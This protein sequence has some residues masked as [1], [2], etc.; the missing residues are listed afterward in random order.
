MRV[1]FTSVIA[2]AAGKLGGNSFSTKHGRVGVANLAKLQRPPSSRQ[3]KNRRIMAEASRLWRTITPAERQKWNVLVK[4]RT[5]FA[6]GSGFKVET[7]FA[8][9]KRKIYAQLITFGSVL[10]TSADP[11]PP[12]TY[13]TDCIAIYTRANDRLVLSPNR[14][15]PIGGQGFAPCWVSKPV[16]PGYTTVKLQ[17]RQIEQSRGWDGNGTAFTNAMATT[18]GSVPAV[19]QVFY[20]KAGFLFWIY[21][22]FPVFRNIRVV[23]S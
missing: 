9:F 3:Y 22:D 6:I 11:A 18:W 20:V 5:L 8:A 2:S 19:G 10:S 21:S 4:S 14:V 16:S 17:W 13:P 12:N 15:T 7:G 23:V 1:K